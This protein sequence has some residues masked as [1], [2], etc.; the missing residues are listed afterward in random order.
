[1]LVQDSNIAGNISK[2]EW[3]LKGF[4]CAIWWLYWKGILRNQLLVI[5]FHVSMTIYVVNKVE[6]GL[7]SKLMFIALVI[8][9]I[10]NDFNCLLRWSFIIDLWVSQLNTFALKTF[11][12]T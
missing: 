8:R 1:M 2:L 12:C 11:D 6:T 5:I 4:L 10:S 3:A 7:S 9:V